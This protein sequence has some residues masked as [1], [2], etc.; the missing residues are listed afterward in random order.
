MW[1]WWYSAFIKDRYSD[2]RVAYSDVYSSDD[3]SDVNDHITQ[4]KD[5][6]YVRKGQYLLIEQ[7]AKWKKG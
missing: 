1:C 4:L 7:I 3:E 2:A 6:D 5:K